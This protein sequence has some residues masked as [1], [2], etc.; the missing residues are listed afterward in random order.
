MLWRANGGC[1]Y[2][3]YD[4]FFYLSLGFG[5]QVVKIQHESES[6]T[7]CALYTEGYGAG[8]PKQYQWYLFLVVWHREKPSGCITL[9]LEAAELV[10]V[11]CHGKVKSPLTLRPELACVL[12]L[13]ISVWHSAAFLFLGLTWR[14][15]LGLHLWNGFTLKSSPLIRLL[16]DYHILGLSEPLVPL[17]G[18]LLAFPQRTIASL[19]SHW[20]FLHIC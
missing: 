8:S 4:D 10:H 16:L 7:M 2:F 12:L 9:H 13:S 14:C 6:K 5:F 20:T 3:V 1:I 11:W 19:N 15:S 17:L 18:H